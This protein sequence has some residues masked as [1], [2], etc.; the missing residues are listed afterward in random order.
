MHNK[1][2]AR[3]GPLG[4]RGKKAEWEQEM[5]SGQLTPQLYQI[6]SERSLH[7]VL[8]RRS[9]NELGLNIIPPTIQPIVD[10]LV[11][12][13]TQIS[14]GDLEL[15]P[16]EDLLTKVIGPEHPGRTRAVGHDVGLRKGMQGTDK[17]KRKKHENETIVK[18]QTTIDLMGSQLAKLQAHFDL[19]QGSRN[20]APDDVSLGV[21]QNN[22]GSTPTLDALDAIKM[23]TPCELV[24][25]YG[26]LDQKCA[27]GLVF[28]YGNGLI[29][30]L[31]LRENHLKVLIDDIDSRY[32]NFP[33]PVM[34]KE[35]ANLQ[36]A[37]GTVIQWPRIAIIPAN[38]QR[39]KKQIPTTSLVPTISR[40]GT[41]K[42]IP[43]QTSSKARPIEYLRDCLKTNQVV[44]IVA[45]S[46]ILEVGTYDF[47]V[48]CE[49]YFRLLRK[50]TIDASIITAWQ[51][52]LHS[53]VRTRM[54]KCAF[55]NP[56][57]ILGEACQKNP[58]GVVSYL[59]DSI[60]LHHGKLFLIAPYLQNKHWVLLVI[61]FRNR[62]VYIL[63]S[64][65]D[66]IE[67]SADYHYL[68]KKHVDIATN[69]LV[70]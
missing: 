56:Y 30:T 45:D 20:H 68:L 58:E 66:R 63:D 21:Q 11:D 25:P 40:A 24:L 38:E 23:P 64:L 4:Y 28:P 33:V 2:P 52:I 54:N 51:L 1:N 46:G 62:V 50:Q 53:M 5:A 61:S 60:R 55:L 9:K 37:V 17:K 69:N 18:L 10:K 13:Q 6:K 59:V 48:T 22:C 41:K 8:G 7:Y 39:A 3:V 49:E 32:E 12:V 57:N 29:H 67:K 44:N 36:G 27:K 70:V 16:G 31:P 19:Q 47:S 65:K 35:V 43:N 14:E 34:T 15:S 26:E 42:N